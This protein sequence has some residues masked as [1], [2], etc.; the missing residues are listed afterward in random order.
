V[1]SA[2]TQLRDAGVELVGDPIVRA[3]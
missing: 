2:L 1:D 3:G